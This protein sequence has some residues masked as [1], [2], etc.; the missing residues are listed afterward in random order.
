MKARVFGWMLDFVIIFMAINSRS[1]FDF[2]N[3]DISTQTILI[4]AAAATSL[5]F[6]KFAFGRMMK[7]DGWL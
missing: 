7:S 6:L 1:G 5:G 4:S 2:G 3:W